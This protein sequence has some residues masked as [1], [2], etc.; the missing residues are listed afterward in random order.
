MPGCGPSV[1]AAP[2]RRRSV[3][4]GAQVVPWA[5]NQFRRPVGVVAI[6]QVSSNRPRP[7]QPSNAASTSLAARSPERT[8]PS[9]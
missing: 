4:V 7:A 8:A 6:V 2:V 5:A 3:A 9:M 1:L